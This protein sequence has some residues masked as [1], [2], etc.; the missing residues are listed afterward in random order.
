M[1]IGNLDGRLVIV[2]D[3]RA[4]DVETVSD[5]RFS[6]RI[7]RIYPRWGEFHTWALT[8]DLSSSGVRFDPADLGAPVST[9]RQI[10]ALG[11]NYREH[12]A[13]TGFGLPE[14]LPPVFTKF[15]SAITGP[16]STVVLPVGNVDWEVELAV[17]ISRAAHHIGAEEV[18]SH[19]AGLTVA[20]DLSERIL[21]MSGPS[22][23]F[24]LGK[25]Y[26]GFLPMGPT[27]VTPDELP[28]PDALRL[29]SAVNGEVVQDGNTRDLIV[30]VAESIARLSDVITLYPGD[31][32]LTGTPAGVGMGRSPQRYLTVGDE[33][34]STIEGLGTIRQRFIADPAL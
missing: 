26:P 11:L 4:I 20:Q 14:G 6:A 1:R 27:L 15:A 21:Q 16:E 22:P 18:W 33:L 29:Q 34:V 5:G 12:A 32:I 31:V 8:R 28:H 13:E 19:V 7:D 17:V 3:N 24:S 30:P 10:I 23:Q 25:S 9:P 2:Q